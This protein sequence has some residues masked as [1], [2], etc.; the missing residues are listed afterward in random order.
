M[1]TYQ[2]EFV[3]RPAARCPHRPRHPWW[4]AVPTRRP[5]PPPRP[6][7]PTSAPPRSSA[8][9]RGRSRNSSAYERRRPAR[10]PWPPSATLARHGGYSAIA[11]NPTAA[12]LPVQATYYM[13]MLGSTPA[14]MFMSSGSGG[15][16]G[17]SMDTLASMKDSLLDNVGKMVDGKAA[18]RDERRGGQLSK[19]GPGIQPASRRRWP[20][21]MHAGGLSVPHGW[22]TGAPA[23]RR[24]MPALPATSVAAAEHDARPAQQPVLAGVDG[25][26]GRTRDER[27][28][29]PGRRQGHAPLAR[30]RVK[31]LSAQR[32]SLT[33]R[34]Q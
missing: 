20:R 6:P 29:L 34:P 8:T 19:W 16:A 31:I 23:N 3:S 9:A 18:H 14:R 2:H 22:H 5:R 27:H 10:R 12:L 24:A 33:P 11:A 30:R 32:I 13:G 1:D 4:P 17:A 15:G 21:A 28:G 26:T 25:R 7:R